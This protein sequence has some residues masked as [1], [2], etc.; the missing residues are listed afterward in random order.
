MPDTK[1]EAV[2]P[3]SVYQE[4]EVP[5]FAVLPSHTVPGGSGNYTGA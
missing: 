3:V 2:T 1:S 5:L 4:Q